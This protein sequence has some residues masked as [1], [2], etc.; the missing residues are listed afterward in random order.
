MQEN[1]QISTR[2][3]ILPL[4]A[5][6]LRPNQSVESA[7]FDRDLEPNTLHFSCS[8]S[9]QMVCVLTFLPN[10]CP[11]MDLAK[12]YQLRGM[13]T[14]TVAHGKGYGAKLLGFACEYLQENHLAAAVWCNARESAIGFYEK[15]GFQSVGDY[16]EIAGIGRH[17]VMFKMLAINA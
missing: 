7:H 8:A 15:L 12:P 2:D 17:V 11:V 9:G 13:A 14:D 5:K 3:E 6:M 1:C 10:V 4:R 16:F